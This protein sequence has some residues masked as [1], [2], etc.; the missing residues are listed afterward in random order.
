LNL[1][2]FIISYLLLSALFSLFFIGVLLL[3]FKTM[4]KT[5]HMNETKWSA[6]FRYKNGKGLYYIMAFPYLLTLVIMFPLSKYWFELINFEYSILGTI[7]I[8]ILLTLTGIFKF[9]KLKG[10]IQNR[11]L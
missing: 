11:L 10:I 1:F 7:S 2:I 5:F 8:I 6:L 4:K 3:F 9:S